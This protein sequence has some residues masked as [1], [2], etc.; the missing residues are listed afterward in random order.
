MVVA[1]RQWGSRCNARESA[2]TA[3]RTRGDRMDGVR[4]MVLERVVLIVLVVWMFAI[5]IMKVEIHSDGILMR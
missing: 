3:G 1:E 5:M 4:R 2:N